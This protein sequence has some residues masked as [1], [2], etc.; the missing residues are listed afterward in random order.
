MKNPV[1]VGVQGDAAT[2]EAL[3]RAA[4]GRDLRVGWLDL[5]EECPVP[6]P[7]AAAAE[8]G[9][10]R[11]VAAAGRATVATKSR[12]GPAVLRDLVR[13]HFLG[14]DLVLVRGLDLFPRLAWV[15]GSWE[16]SESASAKRRLDLGQLLARLRRP[17][18]RW[19][20]PGPGTA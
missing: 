15:A 17:A 6:A 5:E 4:A 13:E 18:L 9:A 16:L 11:S 1:L 12:K 20:A 3:F 8:L 10:Y 7:L 14:A 2:F 19:K